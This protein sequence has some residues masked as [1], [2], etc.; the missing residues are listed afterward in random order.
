MI[1]RAAHK[2]S[3]Q[4]TGLALIAGVSLGGCA[5]NA[6]TYAQPSDDQAALEVQDHH[7]HHSHG[8]VTQFIAM[9][10]DT[11]GTDDAK[12]PQIEKIQNDLNA[13]MAPA[14]DVERILLMTCS[15]GVS[16]G[17]IDAAK[18][19]TNIR[20]LDGVATAAHN[21]SFDALNQ[22]HLILSPSERAAL[23]DKVQAHWEIWRQVNEEAEAGGRGKG[24][25]LA[26][27][28]QELDLSAD[29]IERM[30]AALRTA[31]GGLH[32]RFDVQKAE[33]HLQAF[34]LAFVGDSFDAKSVTANANGHLATRG[35]MR[36]AMFYETVTPLLTSEQRTKLAEHLRERASHLPTLSSK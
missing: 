11:L 31:L 8:G 25:W 28:N 10:L 4:L 30:S 21:C 24:S 17:A 5:T 36:M 19:D 26:D 14:R 32:G 1:Q 18:I 27:L 33:A 12:R 34:D 9:S 35:S 23:V 29:Q 7:R 20:L 3:F 2:S 13:C 15:D 16:A 22:L 6:A